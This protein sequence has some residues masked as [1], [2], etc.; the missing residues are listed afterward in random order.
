M[1]FSGQKVQS[2]ESKFYESNSTGTQ[3]RQFQSQKSKNSQTIHNKIHKLS[4]FDSMIDELSEGAIAAVFPQSPQF[5]RVD[6]AAALD[7]QIARV[8]RR[9]VH[10]VRLEQVSGPGHVARF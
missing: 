2:H 5:E 3:S 4:H 10:F 1:V 8:V 6:F 9:V 7:A